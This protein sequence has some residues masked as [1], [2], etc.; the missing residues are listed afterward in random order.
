MSLLQQQCRGKGKRN[1]TKPGGKPKSNKTKPKRVAEEAPTTP[2]ADSSGTSL[3]IP[4]QQ[5]ILNVF[6]TTLLPAEQLSCPEAQTPSLS[7]AE[8][9]QAIKAHLYRRDFVKAFTEADGDAL[10][11]YAL[12]WSAGRALGY[13]AVFW[14]LKELLFAEVGGVDVL[15]VG[16]GAG[17]EIMALAGV[18]RAL[19]EEWREGRLSERF[20][21]LELGDVGDCENLSFG[22]AGLRVTAV[23]IADWS[24]VVERLEAGMRSKSVPSPKLCP[25]P[26]LPA[27]EDGGSAPF[28][29]GFRKQDVL[30]LSEDDIRNLLYPAASRPETA[31]GTTLVTL[32]FTLNELFSTSI[33]KTVSFLLRLADVLKPGAILL[34]VDSPGSYSTVSLGSKA[35]SPQEAPD[36]DETSP[37][38]QRKY[39]MRFL[40]AHTLLSVAQEKW[41]CVLSDE[42]RWFRRDRDALMYHVGEGIG[43]ED[44]RYQIHVYRRI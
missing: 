21:G 31:L 6:K 1:T 35:N 4:L 15:C 26:L 34:I 11:A 27:E 44:M 38:S 19:W 36:A 8:Q 39:P 10:R 12:R 29:V 33:P 3:P 17:A 16:G 14:G 42:S 32:M 43:L 20:S 2:Q 28:S 22:V 25:V 37:S 40:L 5:L 9:I 18:W 41:E 23:D 13:A 30:S 24:G 7:L